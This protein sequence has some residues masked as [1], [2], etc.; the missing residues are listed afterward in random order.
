M[1]S[2]TLDD[3]KR[4]F[5]V[6]ALGLTE[7]ADLNRSIA[8]LEREFF[9]GDTQKFQ[10]LE[11]TRSFKTPGME[12]ASEGTFEVL[13]R[14]GFIGLDASLIIGQAGQIGI[15]APAGQDAWL[16]NGGTLNVRAIKTIGGQLRLGFYGNTPVAK[17][18]AIAAPVAAPAAYDQAQAQSVVNAVNAIR[19][20]L[21][22]IGIT[23]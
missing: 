21:T 15:N 5:Y 8:D 18:A 23:A 9:G 3:V 2:S 20:A 13:R 4:S 17:A 14:R 16:L 22:N 19:T 7:G 1:P 11:V 10:N 6:Q 12:F